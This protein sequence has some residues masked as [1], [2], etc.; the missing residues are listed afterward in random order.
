MAALSTGKIGTK[1]NTTNNNAKKKKEQQKHRYEILNFFYVD[2]RK[3]IESSLCRLM[4]AS[5]L[6]IFEKNSEIPV[7]KIVARNEKWGSRVGSH[8]PTCKPS[9]PVIKGRSCLQQGSPLRFSTTG[10][11]APVK[12]KITGRFGTKENRPRKPPTEPVTTS[13]LREQATRPI[14]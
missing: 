3:G 2:L 7:K 12:K 13:R 1:N 10:Y 14:P 8:G 6:E 11:A 9:I 5:L 4:V